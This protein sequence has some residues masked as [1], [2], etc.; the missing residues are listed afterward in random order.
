M[1]DN[2]H[3]LSSAASFA[4]IL[5]GVRS[6]TYIRQ[7][8]GLTPKLYVLLLVVTR[9]H[10][11]SSIDSSCT[12]DCD[13]EVSRGGSETV[14]LQMMPLKQKLENSSTFDVTSRNLAY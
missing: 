14:S 5:N 9:T 10:Q 3:E 1:T 11:L 8:A 13:E 2:G 4:K 7:L 6:L 12:A